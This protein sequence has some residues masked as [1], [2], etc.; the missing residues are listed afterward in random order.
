MAV[1]FLHWIETEN[2]NVKYTRKYV[3][4]I[5][6]KIV[7]RRRTNRHI[8]SNTFE[9][10][11]GSWLCRRHTNISQWIVCENIQYTY[12][13]AS[14]AR[15]CYLLYP[16]DTLTKTINIKTWTDALCESIWVRSKWARVCDNWNSLSVSLKYS[17]VKKNGEHADRSLPYW[18]DEAK[19][20]KCYTHLQNAVIC[21]KSPH[22]SHTQAQTKGLW[23]FF[24]FFSCLF[25]LSVCL[26]VRSSI[27]Q[28]IKFQILYKLKLHA[29]V[30][31]SVKALTLKQIT[32]RFSLNILLLNNSDV[33]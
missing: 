27:N 13:F 17:H 28:I 26:S 29:T 11:N 22:S 1:A 19:K 15:I 18:K 31:R 7:K 4:Y 21:R 12:E 23:V 24:L 14:F 16:C 9:W 33:K 32:T 10:M 6:I 20:L 5:L 8:R 3:H 25:F 30:K 2:R